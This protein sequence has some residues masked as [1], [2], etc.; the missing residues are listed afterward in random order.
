[1]SFPLDPNAPGGPKRSEY[2]SKSQAAGYPRQG[3]RL[4]VQAGTASRYRSY[5]AP[6]RRARV[7][8]SYPWTKAATTA[9]N[10]A[11]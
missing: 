8:S 5:S 11:A 10:A 7:G 9:Q 2:L 4:G 6:K 3:V 1:M